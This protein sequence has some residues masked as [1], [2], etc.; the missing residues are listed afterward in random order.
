MP[1]EYESPSAAYLNGFD[2]VPVRS[3]EVGAGVG[4]ALVV[5][6]GVEPGVRSAWAE[7]ESAH[8]ASVTAARAA[9]SSA[10]AARWYAARDRLRIL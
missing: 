8:P 1:A 3:V 6:G 10:T 2:G 7:P 9:A 5:A 4:A